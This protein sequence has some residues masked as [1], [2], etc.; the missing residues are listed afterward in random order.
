[1]RL[2]VVGCSGSVPGPGSPASCYV[3]EHDGFR[4]VLD[5]GSGAVGPLGSL[6]GLDAIDAVH[7]SHLHPDHFLD[8][9]P[10]YVALRY[11]PGGVRSDPLPVLGPA[12]IRARVAAAYGTEGREL[13]RVFGFTE[14]EPGARDVGPYSL[15]LVRTA[16]PVTC[17]A[18]RVEAGGRALVFT[19]D[20]GPSGDVTALAAGAD[21]L[22]GE[23][24][25]VEEADNP[26]DLHLTG[27]DLGRMATA[28]GVGRLLVTHVPPWY[29]AAL[30]LG[31]VQAAFAGPAGLATA[32]ASYDV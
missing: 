13:D 12:G 25:T 5:L 27:S 10:L 31:R 2:T 32:G 22:L 29:D 14:V 30:V 4:L 18:V 9:C 24:S 17:H 21:L 19:G 23:A 16:H 20:T 8:L 6:V 15:T 3:V 28:A 7:V 26:P 1:V 11:A